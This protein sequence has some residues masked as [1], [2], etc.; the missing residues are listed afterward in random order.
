MKRIIL[1]LA[2][3]LFAY[4]PAF[5]STI[6]WTDWTSYTTGLYGTASGNI[7]GVTVTYNGD[8]TFA[9]TGTGTNYWTEGTP[10][11]Y[12]GNA[13]VD[14]APTAA[15]MVA[16]S[17]V[18]TNTVTFSQAL[19]NPVMAIGSQGQPGYPVSYD[20]NLPFTVLSEGQGYWGN[21]W[22]NL[23]A[24]DILQGYEL[25]GVI[26]FTGSIS[27]ITWA[28]SPGE[29]WHGFTIGVAENQ[30]QPVPEPATLLLVGGGL[31]GLIFARRRFKR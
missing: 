24:G 26:Q 23:Y 15:E 9:Q 3:A 1:G 21:G 7:D 2:L 18:S 13:V 30:T 28:V 17:L 16:M 29:Y 19:L 8:V 12:T 20:F 5:A 31:A 11:P 6:D 10:A 25:H 22:Y 27:S 4:Q 14:T